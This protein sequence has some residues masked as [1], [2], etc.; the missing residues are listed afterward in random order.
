MNIKGGLQSDAYVDGY[1]I[2][3]CEGGSCTSLEL[4]QADTPP[5]EATMTCLS[6]E[7]CRLLAQILTHSSDAE[8]ARSLTGPSASL[9]SGE[10]EAA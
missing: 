3:E 6:D 8:P 9:Q 2:E 1:E 10:E 4:P 5:L 7:F